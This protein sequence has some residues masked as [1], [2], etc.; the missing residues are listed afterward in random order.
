[1]PPFPAPGAPTATAMPTATQTCTP[2]VPADARAAG[3]PW[4]RVHAPDYTG[5]AGPVDGPRWWFEAPQLPALSRDGKRVL[6]FAVDGSLGAPPNLTLVEERLADRVALAQTPL[7]D[8]RAFADAH[9]KEATIEGRQRAYA[10]LRAKVEAEV[11]ALDARLGAEG[12]APLTS[13]R[14]DIGAGE[15]QP[16]CAM[17]DQQVWCGEDVRLAYHEPDLDLTVR[18][19]TSH[20]HE[21]RW[22][23]PP[24]PT[25]DP[26]VTLSVGGCLG[27][28][29]MDR[30]RG[31]V[32]MLLQY[33][34]H[35]A[36]GD[37]CS[38][39]D[40]WQVMPLPAPPGPPA[41]PSP[42]PATCPAG[43]SAIPAGTFTM[44]SISGPAN[45]RPAHSVN[46]AAFCLDT[47]EVTVAAYRA[48]VATGRCS[49]PAPERWIGPGS[50]EG[51]PSPGCTWGA[52][53]HDDHP[54][55]CASFTFAETYCGAM[56]KR[57]PTEAEWEYAARGT[58]GRAFP[59]GE[60]DREAGLCAGGP[61]SA[62]CPAGSSAA[63]LSPFGVRD[64]GASLREWTASPFVSYDGCDATPGVAV[65]GGSWA[66]RDHGELRAARRSA[67][68]SS[69]RGS[70]LGFRC[71][72]SR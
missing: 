14:V 2:S 12:W 66:A 59:W 32:L 7:L 62:T 11:V 31:L 52:A 56:G 67:M 27:A 24:Q 3:G 46:V 10:T 26:N 6:L 61:R 25:G 42:P 40:R 72:V 69:A 21:P 19:R 1:M 50:W 9:A 5:D 34:C 30:S 20:R 39:P 17:R 8:P 51:A 53:G 55:N 18:G 44:G 57:L 70:D 63:D 15:T 68:P 49:S 16:G 23:A 65:R 33:A 58:D 41:P 47:T 38:V 64:L 13:C 4:V 29:W 54:L 43:M 48:C 60:G 36:A 45:E 22:L 37:G 28:V 71:A 35:G